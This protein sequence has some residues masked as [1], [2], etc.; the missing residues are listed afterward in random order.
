VQVIT[1]RPRIDFCPAFKQIAYPVFAEAYVSRLL[2][3]DEFR[4]HCDRYRTRTRILEH[5]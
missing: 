2:D 5:L 4:A 3:R 1:G